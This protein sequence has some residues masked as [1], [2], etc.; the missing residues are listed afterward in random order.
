MEVSPADPLPKRSCQAAQGRGEWTVPTRCSTLGK[1]RVT[2][3]GTWPG[4]VCAAQ[5]GTRSPCTQSGAQGDREGEKVA[6]PCQDRT[7]AR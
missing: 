4:H 1:R 2:Q 3:E 6:G 5:A 7:A